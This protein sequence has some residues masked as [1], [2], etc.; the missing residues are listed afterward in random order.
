MKKFTCFAIFASLLIQ[1]CSTTSKLKYADRLYQDMK[2]AES[3][4]VLRSVKEPDSTT[5]KRIA[6]VEFKLA[7]MQRAAQDV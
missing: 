6:K 7:H 1:G 5:Y 2:Y 4:S 3:V